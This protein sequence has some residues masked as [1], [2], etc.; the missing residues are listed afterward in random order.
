MK[1][2]VQGMSLLVVSFLLSAS[3]SIKSIVFLLLLYN[4]V[5]IILMFVIGR[6]QKQN[7]KLQEL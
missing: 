7:Q 2:H 5:V 4:N 1:V 6:I 3:L